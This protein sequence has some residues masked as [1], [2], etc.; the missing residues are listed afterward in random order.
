MPEGRN[1]DAGGKSPQEIYGQR[2]DVRCAV[3]LVGPT[4]EDLLCLNF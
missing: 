2:R 4:S 1:T 3:R